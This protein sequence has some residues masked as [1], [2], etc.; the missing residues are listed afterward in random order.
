MLKKVTLKDIAAQTG[1]SMMTVSRALHGKYGVQNEVRDKILLTA[2]KMGYVPARAVRNFQESKNNTMTVGLVIPHFSNSFFPEI[3][4][5]I[6]HILS[7][8]GFRTVV[9]CCYNDSI[10]EFHEILSLIE[11]NVDGIIW[12]PV[13]SNTAKN[14]LNLIQKHHVP[15]VFLDRKLENVRLDSVTV[16]DFNGMRR[17]VQYLLE[18]GYKKFAYLNTCL[19]SY[20]AHERFRGFSS[21]MNEAG[22]KIRDEWLLSAIPNMQGG[23]AAANQLI[24]QQ[25]RPEIICCFS[26]PLA[27]GCELALLKHHISVPGEIS[28]TGFSN[29]FETEVAAVPITTVEQHPAMLSEKAA[30]LLFMR[31]MSPGLNF[32]PINHVC[33]TALVIRDSTC[34]KI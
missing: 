26:D 25:D 31:M 11:L 7:A 5:N 3:I 6:D 14:T 15:V 12:S 9:C 30:N 1:V 2:R 29:V 20:T 33:E 17:L 27:L 13:V 18:C 22:L 34:K 16:D 8:H 32:E 10:K 19:D 4:E 28:V 21:S 23:Q 24:Q